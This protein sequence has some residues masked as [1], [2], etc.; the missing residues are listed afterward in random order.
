MS[1][2]EYFNLF[3]QKKNKSH[4]EETS[5]IDATKRKFSYATQSS[6]LNWHKPDGS[7]A[8]IFDNHV[9]I[10][11]KTDWDLCQLKH[12]LPWQ[13][14][15]GNPAFIQSQSQRLIHATPLPSKLTL[16]SYKIS[17]PMILPYLSTATTNNNTKPK[18]TFTANSWRSHKF[19][20]SYDCNQKEKFQSPKNKKNLQ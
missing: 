20:F 4:I 5:L 16:S 18:S 3:S 10:W 9:Q 12:H 8:K 13:I 17:S 19:E 6:A 7:K 14:N 11:S 1:F 2:E 15:S